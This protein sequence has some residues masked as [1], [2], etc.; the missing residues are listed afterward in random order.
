MSN[1]IE[2]IELTS[3]NDNRKPSNGARAS[4]PSAPAAVQRKKMKKNPGKVKSGSLQSGIVLQE[5]VE[6]L[7]KMKRGGIGGELTDNNLPQVQMECYVE[8]QNQQK[9]EG[10]PV[11]LYHDSEFGCTPASIDGSKNNGKSLKC[12]CRLP[13]VLSFITKGPNKNKPY[14][15]CSKSPKSARCSYFRW[16]YQSEL[17]R[18]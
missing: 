17:M 11:E 4:F 3:D 6:A 8:R 15:H 2:V 1:K 12:S 5:D 9:R 13:V 14:N 10:K 7:V 18:W 16:A